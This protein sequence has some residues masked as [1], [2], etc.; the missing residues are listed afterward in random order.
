MDCVLSHAISGYTEYIN[1]VKVDF[2]QQFLKF[3]N[4]FIFSINKIKL[5]VIQFSKIKY[6]QYKTILGCFFICTVFIG[7]S[8]YLAI[9]LIR[10]QSLN[11]SSPFWMTVPFIE[12]GNQCYSMEFTLQNRKPLQDW[13]NGEGLGEYFP[14]SVSLCILNRVIYHGT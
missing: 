8:T 14:Y 7:A 10:Q 2:F 9:Y 1:I 13:I 6:S 3:K 4:N 12:I 11:I 5:R